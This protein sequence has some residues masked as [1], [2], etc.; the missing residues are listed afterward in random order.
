MTLLAAFQTLLHRYSGM[1]DICVGS[2]I[3]N[4]NR[5]EVEGLIGFVVNTLVLH[6]NLAGN[7]TFVDLLRRTRKMAFGAYSHQDLPFEQ[8][9]RAITPNRDV[10]HSSLFQVLFVLQNAP[11]H[12]PP[13]PNLT[14]RLLTGSHNGTAKFDLTLGLTEMPEGLVGIFEYNCDL[15]DSV[16]DRAH[17]RCISDDC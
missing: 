17:G 14:P 13:L 1:D 4:R 12:L 9:L 8:L 5:A 6:G 11:S 15:F 3:A 2:P 16:H 7:P 10:R